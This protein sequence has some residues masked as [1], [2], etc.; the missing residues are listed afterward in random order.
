MSCY[1]CLNN[2]I[3][4]VVTTSESGYDSLAYP[5]YYNII[6][7]QDLDD[8]EQDHHIYGNLEDDDL[9]ELNTHHHHAAKSSSVISVDNFGARG[10]GKTDDTQVFEEAWKKACSSRGAVLVV[11][12]GKTYLLKPI[13]FSGPCTSP[14]QIKIYGTLEASN[15]RS[16][17]NKD[18]KHWLLFES[19]Q[20]LRVEG[21][22]TINGNGLI[23]WQNSCKV[24]KKKPCTHAPTA[25]TFYNC[26]N[27]ITS[28]LKIKDSQQMHLVFDT[29]SNVTAIGLVVNAPGNSPNTDGIHISNS[30]KVTVLNS[31]IGTGDD[32]ISIVSGSEDVVAKGITCGPGHGISIGSLGSKNSEAYVSSVTIDGA[33]ISN[34]QNGVRIKSWQGGSGVASNINFKNIQM[35]NVDNPIII[36]QNYCDQSGPCK[37][38]ISAVQVKNV[39]YENIY[40][41]S[42]S[43]VAIKL[44][45]SKSFPCQGI[46]LQNINLVY[47]KNGPKAEAV[48]VNAKPSYSGNV[49]PR[50]P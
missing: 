28:N 44:D 33:T 19:I 39:V 22:G 49:T 4:E 17:Y 45:C 26:K 47:A 7:D 24:N 29:C 8:E 23:W 6:N 37:Q 5:S 16:D 42:E 38:Q 46:H 43:E 35:K 32:C 48:C 11:P 50:C 10:D 27:V 1:F 20:N 25:L 21:G 13:S 36:D 34:T 31:V 3:E 14:I 12:R 30:Q 2:S 15:D 40:G 41:T 18:S 9:I